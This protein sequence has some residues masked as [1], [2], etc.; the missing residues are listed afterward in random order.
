M[1]SD[2]EDCGPCSWIFSRGIVRAAGKLK[3][4]ILFGI[5]SVPLAADTDFDFSFG[6]RNLRCG[7]FHID[8]E[9]S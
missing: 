7:L 8:M 1:L 2:C 5:E 6:F 3:L 9:V 4:Q